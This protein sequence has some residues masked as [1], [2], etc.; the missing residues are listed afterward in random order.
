M[1]CNCLATH[2]SRKVNFFFKS[3]QSPIAKCS[4]STYSSSKGFL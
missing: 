2:R 3:M 4:P 1:L